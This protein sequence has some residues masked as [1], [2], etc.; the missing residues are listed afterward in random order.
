MSRV[1]LVHWPALKR[2]RCA[3]VLFVRLQ[4]PIQEKRMGMETASGA[5]CSMSGKCPDGEW[6]SVSLMK[7]RFTSVTFHFEP[8][9]VHDR[10]VLLV[11][12]ISIAVSLISETKNSNY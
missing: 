3:T 11:A 8:T 10:L 2:Y 6:R 12:Y 7:T 5:V 4:L 1:L 9:I